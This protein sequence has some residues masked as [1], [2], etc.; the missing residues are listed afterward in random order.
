MSRLAIGWPILPSPTNPSASAMHSSRHARRVLPRRSAMAPCLSKPAGVLLTGP[1][2]AVL[3]DPRKRRRGWEG[4]RVKAPSFDYLRPRS[5]TEALDLLSQHGDEGKVIAGGQSLVPAL[6]LRLLA[7]SV[8]ID[9]G[10]LPELK[11][12]A[13]ADGRVRLGALTRDVE[14]MRSPEVA[15]HLPLIAAAMPHLSHAAIRNRG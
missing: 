12:L 4:A 1:A 10:D 9:I 14:L 8:L 15:R 13:V 7:P 2:P 11:G 3:V 5:L 6:N